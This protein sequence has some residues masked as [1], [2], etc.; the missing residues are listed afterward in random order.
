MTGKH[1]DESVP[2]LQVRTAL[3]TVVVG[4]LLV[5]ACAGDGTGIDPR[6]NAVASVAV[7]SQTD[8]LFSL[9]ETAQF[10]ATAMNADGTAL[11][12]QTFK[13]SSSDES[14][15]VVDDDG[16]VTAVANGVA[17]ISAAVSGVSGAAEVAV[18]Q[19][20]ATVTVTPASVTINVGQT[21]QFAAAATDAGG[22]AVTGVKFLWVSSDQSIAT[23]DSTGR[24]TARRDGVTAIT[25]L[26]QG[27]PGNAVLTVGASLPENRLA[28]TTQPTNATAGAALSPAIQVEV[29]DA[30]NNLVTNSRSPVTLSFATN[31]GGGTLSGTVTVNAVRG[32]ASFSGISI[33]KAATGYTLQAS[34]G[35]LTAATSSAFNI[36]PGPGTALDFSVQPSN[37]LGN[38]N[39]APA[40][41]VTVVDQFG[42]VATS[43]TNQ[44]DL[45][46]G[47]NP[48]AS[49]LGQGGALVGTSSVNAVNG[50]AVFDNIGIDR[51]A[52]G[53]TL[54]ATGPD[55][56]DQAE[57]DPFEVQLVFQNVIAGGMAYWFYTPTTCGL[58]STGSYCWGYG[59]AGQRGDGSVAGND[60]VPALVLGNHDFVQLDFGDAHG[61]AVTSANE[62]YCW[63]Y[64]VFGQLGTGNTSQQNEPALVSGGLAF[65][66]IAP[67][68]IHTCGLVGTDAYCWGNNDQGQLGDATNTTSNTPVLVAGGHAFAQIDAGA[69]HTCGV[70]TNGDA[71]CWGYGA[72]GELGNGANVSSNAPVLVSGGFTF[73]SV[74]ASRSSGSHSCGVTVSGD[75]YCW[76]N[77]GNGKLGDG[78]TTS[79]NAP[80]LV[81][82]G[83]AWDNLSAGVDHT[84]GVTTSG[85]GYCW[86]NNGNGQ[87][88]DDNFP[89]GSTTRSAVAGGLTFSSITAGYVYS[90]GLASGVAYCWGYNGYGNLGDGS[91]TQ[92]PVPVRV[93]Q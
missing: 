63:G 70:L 39:I 3:A 38:D 41:E 28:F 69:L 93:I 32:I 8:S 82:G 20:V 43:A 67:G 87:L 46:I 57:S 19:Q 14:I 31:A 49:Q 21:Q 59:G 7:T 72:N 30:G 83:L 40:V 52:I 61:C 26:G 12:G 55:F 27:Q 76:G 11:S 22:S 90:C 48:W 78:T 50:V 37:A 47:V 58:T 64:N 65:N 80:V 34:S 42:N 18:A 74:T 33:N 77:N 23:V 79:T 85:T 24:A 6:A 66:S 88:G 92:S 62:G 51:P 53:Y 5:Y 73:T 29:R 13:W 44:V 17:Q 75:A 9:G 54:V 10:T 60:S 35:T 81:S 84:C 71:Y 36:A 86:G 68:S 25:A 1:G 91:R 45:E 4:A 2:K 56:D 15:A 16:T 89:T